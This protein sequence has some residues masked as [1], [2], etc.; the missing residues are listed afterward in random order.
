[1][2]ADTKGIETDRTLIAGQPYDAAAGKLFLID[3]KQIPPAV[4]QLNLK[5]PTDIPNLE[6]PDAAQKFGED[7]L[8][9]LREADK[10]LNAFCTQIEQASN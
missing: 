8:H 9:Q 3:M 7:T 5:L 4:T 10:T 6:A 2:N 1:M